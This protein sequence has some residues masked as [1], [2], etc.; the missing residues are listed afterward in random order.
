MMVLSIQ[1]EEAFSVQ[2]WT[3]ILKLSTMW[4]FDRIRKIAIDQMSVLPMDVAEKI[5]IARDYYVT[6][7]FLPSLND[8]ARLE[9]PV[10]VE[11]VD[12]LGLEYL[13]KIV[14]ARQS[15]NQSLSS[16]SKCWCDQCRDLQTVC[17]KVRFMWEADCT[18]ALRIAFKD[19]LEGAQKIWSMNRTSTD[20][21]V[22]VTEPI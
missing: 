4:E 12:H 22:Y 7:W 14:Q 10:S 15:N 3:S 13:L 9:R 19:E 1:K 18:D 8:Y 6:T 11:D 16:T 17:T 21:S 5:A 20:P 2:E